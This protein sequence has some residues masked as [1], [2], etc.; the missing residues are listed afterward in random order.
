MHGVGDGLAERRGRVVVAVGQRA[1]A[2]EGIGLLRQQ[3][4]LVEGLGGRA[5]V[6][7]SADEQDVVDA[8]A[9]ERVELDHHRADGLLVAL[10]DVDGVGPLLGGGL[11][12]LA[13]GPLGDDAFLGLRRGDHLGLDAAIERIAIGIED[14]GRGAD[15]VLGQSKCIE[16]GLGLPVIHHLAGG[17]EPLLDVVGEL[18]P[19]QLLGGLGLLD[20]RAG[21]GRSRGWLDGRLGRGRCGL[22]RGGGGGRRG[23]R[24]LRVDRILHRGHPDHRLLALLG[25]LQALGRELVVRVEFEG[26]LEERLG[27]RGRAL[28]E[29][30]AAQFGQLLGQRRVVVGEG[31]NTG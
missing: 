21:F 13:F 9:H 25:L 15:E 16:G 7:Q 10:E 22:A 23:R 24:R 31:G 18:L 2:L 17:L 30:L 1:A 27:G 6:A 12:S 20:R 11:E 4:G 29:C 8:L 5:D 14:V 26:L 28:V 19:R 3:P